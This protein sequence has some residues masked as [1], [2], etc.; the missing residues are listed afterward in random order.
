MVFLDPS[1][2][3][4]QLALYGLLAFLAL[5]GYPG[6]DGNSHCCFPFLGLENRSDRFGVSRIQAVVA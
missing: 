1:V 5:S 2:E 6:V 4:T 3:G